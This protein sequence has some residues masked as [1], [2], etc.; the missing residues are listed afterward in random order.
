MKKTYKSLTTVLGSKH[1]KINEEKKSDE[2][3]KS[4]KNIHSLNLKQK[5]KTNLNI[6]HY[7]ILKYTCHT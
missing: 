7:H 1:S 2:T 6:V 4:P 5:K 3:N